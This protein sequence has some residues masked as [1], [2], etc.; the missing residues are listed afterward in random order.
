MWSRNETDT[1]LQRS[2][3]VLVLLMIGVAAIFFG[4]HRATEFMV[5]VG[6]GVLATGVWLARLWIGERPRGNTTQQHH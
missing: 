6:L 2:V 1:F 5:V 4:G 3:L